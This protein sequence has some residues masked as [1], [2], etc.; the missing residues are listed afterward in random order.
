MKIQELKSTELKKEYKISIPV[1]DVDEKVT[2][3]LNV[4]GAGATIQGFRK[5]KAPI[6]VLKQQYGQRAW[7]EAAEQ[8]VQ[9]AADKVINDN[10]LKP[11][12]Q[13]QIEVETFEQGKDIDIKLSIEVTPKVNI[14]EFGKIAVTNRKVKVSDADINETLENIR[15]QQKDLIDA[16]KTAKAKLGD[17][18]IIDFEGDAEG[19]GKLAGMKGEGAS[20]TLGANQF[21]PGF[22]EQLVGAKAG[23][24]VTVNVTFPKD[25]HSAELA[26]KKT[27]F[28]TKVHAVKHSKPAELNDEFA[29]K[30]GLDSL[31]ALKDH[32][33]K[34]IQ[35]ELDRLSR[36]AT[37]RD[38]LD[39]LDTNHVFDVPQGLVDLEYAEI[40]KQAQNEDDG[41]EEE[42]KAIAERRVRLGI[43]LTEAGE[44][45]AV[46]VT[47]EELRAAAIAEARKYPGQEEKIFEMFNKQPEMLSRLRAPVFEE[48]VVDLILEK[49]KVTEKVVTRDELIAYLE[50]ADTYAKPSSK[51]A[52]AKKPATKKKADAKK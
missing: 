49:A 43:V 27:V 50:E 47:Q 26:G 42:L 9:E 13:P 18:V 8:A 31:K 28:E 51:K 24:D 17:T 52:A 12:M 3:R 48:K 6:A 14:M 2:Q 34:D 40:K 16:P 29:K 22:E 38:M 1:K 44:K 23:D 46:D 32:V 30:L 4:I 36:L 10:K 39:V 15:N 19:V 37:K 21:I 33:E 41:S 45:H 25:Y 20:L 7:A 5:G 11:A 35:V